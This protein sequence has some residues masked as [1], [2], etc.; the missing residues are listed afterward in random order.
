MSAVL[1]GCEK[2]MP[3]L[4]KKL[5]KTI[6]SQYN[7]SGSQIYKKLNV[8]LP[9]ITSAKLVL[10]CAYECCLKPVSKIVKF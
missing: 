7:T 10:C 6:G 9:N 8:L 1:D 3:Y 2:E 5:P 4:A